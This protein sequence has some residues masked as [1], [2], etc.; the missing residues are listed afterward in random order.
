MCLKVKVH[1]ILINYSASEQAHSC[2]ILRLTT[3]QKQV[4]LVAC[5]DSE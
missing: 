1:L 3:P 4:S 2:H 5:Y